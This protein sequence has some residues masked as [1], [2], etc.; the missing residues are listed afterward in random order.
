LFYD[1]PDDQK[2]WTVEDEYM[3]GPD[4]LVAPVLEE[5][6]RIRD[7]YLPDGAE[8]TNVWTGRRIEGGR[9]VVADAPIDR[10]PLYL[11]GDAELPIKE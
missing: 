1:F 2:A 8:W 6:A 3:F 9:R 4:L 7:V 11:K 5:C 10:I